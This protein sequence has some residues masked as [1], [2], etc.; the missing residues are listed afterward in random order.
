MQD[1]TRST[2]AGECRCAQELVAGLA[3]LLDLAH[4]LRSQRL[5]TLDE[6]AN[7]TG[8]TARALE[9]GARRRRFEHV[10]LGKARLMT[11]AQ[12]DKLVGQF[13]VTTFAP[14]EATRELDR[15][16]YGRRGT[17]RFN[18]SPTRR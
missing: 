17:V 13:T 4:E 18:L 5:Y 9:D 2:T 11:A 12:I 8:F 1:G 6:V 10:S 3:Q 7:M 14:D 16:R 15:R